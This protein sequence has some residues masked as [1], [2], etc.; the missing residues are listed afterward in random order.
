M[1]CHVNLQEFRSYASRLLA[2]N[3]VNLQD[4]E[5]M[6]AGYQQEIM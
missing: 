5:D 2:R 4:S 1:A 6:L 3:D